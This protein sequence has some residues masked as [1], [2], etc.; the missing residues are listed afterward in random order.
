MAR[1]IK[2]CTLLSIIV[3]LLLSVTAHPAPN[4]GATLTIQV[5]IQNII[6]V[7]TANSPIATPEAIEVRSQMDIVSREADLE[8]T[9]L[10]WERARQLF[11]QGR[12]VNQDYAIAGARYEN[13]VGP[14]ASGQTRAEKVR[15]QLARARVL[16]LQNDAF[17]KCG[18]VF[19]PSIGRKPKAVTQAMLNSVWG[20]DFSGQLR[21]SLTAAKLETLTLTIDEVQAYKGV[22]FELSAACQ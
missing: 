18:D 3:T 13:A 21:P 16:F 6:L 7:D 17:L 2:K 12:I 10:G 5:R 4:G 20:E 9:K 22:V 8:H 15:A 11:R 19:Q 1:I 14:L